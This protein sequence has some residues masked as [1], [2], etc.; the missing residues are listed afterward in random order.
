MHSTIW[1]RLAITLP[2]IVQPPPFASSNISAAR[3]LETSPSLGKATSKTG[4]REFVLTRYPY[5]LAYEL[6]GD[7]IRILAVFHHRQRRR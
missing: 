2:P 7:E 4:V 3:S 5:L 1:T 6:A